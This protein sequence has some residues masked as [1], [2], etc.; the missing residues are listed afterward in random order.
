MLLCQNASR[1]DFKVFCGFPLLT[2]PFHT[3]RMLPNPRTHSHASHNPRSSMHVFTRRPDI[4]W[5]LGGILAYPWM[6]REVEI[7]N[8]TCA[9]RT[10]WA[11]GRLPS[12]PLSLHPSARWTAWLT[13]LKEQAKGFCCWIY[14]SFHELS[15]FFFLHNTKQ[16]WLCDTY[17]NWLLHSLST[18]S[19][20]R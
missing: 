17:F 7:L 12:H 16:Y 20:L 14:S 6:C 15:S 1:W 3:T 4:S 2:F 18:R 13:H 5:N 8:C 11:S 19:R 10:V 9:G